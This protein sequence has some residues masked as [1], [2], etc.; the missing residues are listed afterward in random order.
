MYISLTLNQI[1]KAT[2]PLPTMVL[3]YFIE[4]RRY[5]WPMVLTVLILLAG[6][7]L[8]VPFDSPDAT[9]Y[10]LVLVCI[11]T[12]STA[13]CISCKARL[14]SHSGEN[15][16]TPVVLLFYSSSA[17]VPVLLIWFLAISERTEVGEYFHLQC[18]RTL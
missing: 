2:T 13:A 10:G 8:A 7:V 11:S 18:A 12:L 14:M 3:G 15:G 17:S 9:P 16:L 4:R 1:F 6:A 5:V